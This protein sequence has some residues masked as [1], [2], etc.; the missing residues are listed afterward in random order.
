ME[1]H[2]RYGKMVFMGTDYYIGQSLQKY[3]EYGE[4]EVQLMRNFIDSDSVVFDVGA[5]IGALTVPLA[6]A[7]GTVIAFEPQPMV[8]ELLKTN[9]V[10]HHNVVA[11]NIGLGS[12]TS[13]MFIPPMNYGDMG[14]FGG[15]SLCE[16]R[17]GTA[18][19]VM[20]I[21]DIATGVCDLI[22]IDVEG[23]ELDVLKGA[24]ETI[25]R[26]QP[27]LYV[28][29]DREAKSAALIS[30]LMELGYRLWWHKPL[31]F[32]EYNY[33]NCKENI[34][35]HVVSCNMLC[36]PAG[37]E[38]EVSDTL[39]SIYGL[40]RITSSADKPFE[41]VQ[42]PERLFVE[43][44]KGWVAVARFGGIGDNMIAASVLPLLKQQ[45]Y[46]VEVITDEK[47]GA[48]FKNNPHIDKLAIK[49]DGDLP[50]DCG[51]EWQKWFRSRSSEY[52]KMIHLSHTIEGLLAHWPS[53]TAFY[54][55]AKV[56]RELCG[57]SYLEMVHD[58]AEVPYEFSRLFYPTDAEVRQAIETRRKVGDTVVGWVVKGSRGDKV[59]PY[60]PMAVARLI[61][62]C[63]VS[64]VLFCGVGDDYK[65]AAAI[66]E[67][68]KNQ[69]GSDAGLHV[70]ST[71]N[72]DDWPTRR[73]LTFAQHM[74][75]MVG[76]DTGV[77]WSVAMEK[78]PKVMLLSHAGI[79]NITKHWVNT[80]TLHAEPERVKCWP[81]HQL[82]DS[83]DTCHANKDNNGA[84]CISDISIDSIINTVRRYLA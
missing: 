19:E 11:H 36:V 77:M 82:H 5:N 3:G 25:T 73:A 55:P 68:V 41:E 31:L 56:R 40:R 17:Q 44:D 79:D 2:G 61:K 53:Q 80:T 49:K 70:A 50:A 72:P 66:Q 78:L 43:E 84:A 64:V 12:R 39:V 45:G 26:C 42:M 23:M 24:F 37:R 6:Q 76:P 21:D 13:T 58:I 69:N 18:V 48:L 9:C 16:D 75:V 34:F 54:W 29:N 74:D 51:L 1:V 47:N 8:F 52:A 83:P 81:C 28:E 4:E 60:S 27:I 46:K 38:Y 65:A 22:K 67:H 59:Y 14:N 62:E 7:S 35:G 10:E 63:G 20:K 57:K 71:G 33:K 30:Y 32:N 15:V